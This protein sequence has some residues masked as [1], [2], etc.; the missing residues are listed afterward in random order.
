MSPNVRY[1]VACRF[2]PLGSGGLEAR[3]FVVE[4]VHIKTGCVLDSVLMNLNSLLQL[5]LRLVPL[6][7]IFLAASPGGMKSSSRTKTYEL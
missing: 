2:V 4:R 5:R 3:P 7:G 6:A 1:V